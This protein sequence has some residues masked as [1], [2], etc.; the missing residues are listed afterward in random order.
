MEK[1]QNAPGWVLTIESMEGIQSVKTYATKKS[2]MNALQEVT[3]GIKTTD[4]TEEYGNCESALTTEDYTVYVVQK[5][6]D[7]VSLVNKVAWTVNQRLYIEKIG[8]PSSYHWTQVYS[9]KALAVTFYNMVVLSYKVSLGNKPEY[10]FEYSD[11]GLKTIIIK[12]DEPFLTL[13]CEATV[14]DKNTG[15]SVPDLI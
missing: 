10:K 2:A 11:D 4:C 14:I 6:E 15:V 3:K 8:I 13:F 5:P 12:N 9:N 1:N 7:A